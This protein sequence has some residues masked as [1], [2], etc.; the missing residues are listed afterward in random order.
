M[1]KVTAFEVNPLGLVSVTV[2]A[3][4]AAT[5]DAGT[6][7]VTWVAPTNLVARG[8]P[9]HCA[10]EPGTKLVPMTTRLNVLAPAVAALGLR[11]VRVGTGDETVN[12]RESECPLPLE[13]ATQTEAKAAAL[14]MPAGIAAVSVVE[15]T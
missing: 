8:E 5:R 4:P 1:V 6:A 3:P 14:N 11:L 15:F 7:A 13:S 2:A 10:A 12:G 9:F